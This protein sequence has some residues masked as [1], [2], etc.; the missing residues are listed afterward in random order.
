[1]KM[2]A[3]PRIGALAGPN[4]QVGKLH[5]GISTSH[6]ER[7]GISYKESAGRVE[8]NTNAADSKD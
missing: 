7:N 5:E 8:M 4:N 1:M 6:R 3:D 2:G